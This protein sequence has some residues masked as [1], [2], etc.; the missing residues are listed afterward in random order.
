MAKRTTTLIL[1]VVFIILLAS[2]IKIASPVTS[3]A[4]TMKSKSQWNATMSLSS[5]QGKNSWATSD[6]FFSVKLPHS[7][8]IAIFN[9][10]TLYGTTQNGKL[11][12]GMMTRNSVVIY[13]PFANN[14][15]KCFTSQP[16]FIPDGFL[17]DANTDPRIDFYWPGPGLSS[18]INDTET[19]VAAAQ[20]HSDPNVS[21]TWNYQQRGTTFF[22]VK[23][24]KNSKVPLT[25]TRRTPFN[26]IAYPKPDQPVVL[27]S[28]VDDGKWTYVYFTHWPTE[29][30]MPSARDLYIAR[31]PSKWAHAK[32]WDVRA[33]QFY[34]TSGWKLYTG[35]PWM[36]KQLR[37][38]GKNMFGAGGTVA[39]NPNGGFYAVT[40][41]LEFI[42][43]KIVVYT[44][45]TATGPF[46]VT[47][48]IPLKSPAGTWNYLAKAHPSIPAPTGK[49]WISVDT[50]KENGSFSDPVSW[51][52]EQWYL[53]DIPRR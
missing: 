20:M 10:D 25:V 2:A 7:N 51:Y 38:V 3:M 53:I 43:D 17:Y 15:N 40:R 8:D 12:S 41:P 46:T 36:L 6:G 50:A 1:I 30:G 39:V 23:Y 5:S 37:P 31:V 27:S 35:R 22:S 19:F 49:V 34:T 52:Y 26:V 14:I 44:A 13:D 33:W 16:L 32:L 18:N 24:N 47:K 48:T 11:L 28:I 42:D 29:Q 9:G 21:S 4:C 45:P